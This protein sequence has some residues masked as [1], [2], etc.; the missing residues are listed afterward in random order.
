MIPGIPSASAK[1]SSQGHCCFCTSPENNQR[2]QRVMLA[3][4]KGNGACAWIARFNCLPSVLIV[5]HPT[6]PE[7]TAQS[8]VL[9]RQQ[10]RSSPY[11]T[12][13]LW[14]LW[15]TAA[16][17]WAHPAPNLR[18]CTTRT[19]TPATPESS[20]LTPA[21]DTASDHQDTPAQPSTAALSPANLPLPPVATSCS[22]P[23]SLYH[24]LLSLA[25]YYSS[26]TSTRHTTPRHNT[27]IISRV[28]L[29]STVPSDHHPT[30]AFPPLKHKT[31]NT[32]HETRLLL[33]QA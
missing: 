16:G 7:Q 28:N 2:E 9:T 26:V 18:T 27:T 10:P 21:P 5:K 4:T 6:E 23:L 19:R 8:R 20:R 3:L 12:H 33:G 25:L 22:Q 29:R 31:S 15:R 30:V 13:N 11:L 24:L 14:P 17:S 32:E 1:G